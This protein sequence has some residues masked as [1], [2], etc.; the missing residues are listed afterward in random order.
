LSSGFSAGRRRCY[1]SAVAIFNPCL[2]AVRADRRPAG[3]G[4][5][6]RPV[7]RMFAFGEQRP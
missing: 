4:A 6:L 7:G 5:R 2:Y 1:L 3:L